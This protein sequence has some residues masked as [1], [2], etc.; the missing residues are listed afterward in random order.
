MHLKARELS[1][2]TRLFD[3]VWY[4]GRY[5]DVARTGLDPFLH[6][7]S[8]GAAEGRNPHPLFDTAWYRAKYLTTAPAG[9]NPLVHYITEGRLKAHD[10]NPLF[11]AAWYLEKCGGPASCGGDPLLHYLATGAAGG[12]NPNPLFDGKWYLA[13]YP[14]VAGAAINP[15]VHY[16][17]AGASEGRNPNPYFDS[18]WYLNEYPDVARSKAD[19]LAHY[20]REGAAAGYNP[21]PVFNTSWYLREYPQASHSGMNPLA[22]YLADGERAG[23]DP[24]LPTRREN[25]AIEIILNSTTGL[26]PMEPQLQDLV[27]AEALHDVPRFFGPPLARDYKA[28]RKLFFSLDRAPAHIVFLPELR[29]ADSV[30][31]ILEILAAENALADA[32]FVVTDNGQARAPTDLPAGVAVRS[33]ADFDD[34]LTPQAEADVVRTL[35]YFLRPRTVFNTNSLACWKALTSSG[36][37]LTLGT[38]FALVVDG[39]DSA[40]GAGE[41][42]AHYDLHFRDCF[43]YFSRL[44]FGSATSRERF[45]DRFGLFGTATRGQIVIDRHRGDDAHARPPPLSPREVS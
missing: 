2:I 40:E 1:L 31:F 39:A 7:L 19:P 45:N 34:G 18:R 28:L 11:D 3:P 16:I 24:S 26:V 5:P 22:H 8:A 35:I 30:A 27:T 17:T 42:F 25:E 12:N 13:K 6:Y 9:T 44:Y 43:P 37:A 36:A 38:G 10:P 41:R 4:L 15:L 14:D 23:N 29:S 33:L 20:L 32:L 21:G